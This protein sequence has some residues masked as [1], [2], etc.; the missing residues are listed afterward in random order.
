MTYDITTVGTATIDTFLEAVD[1]CYPKNKKRKENFYC[2]P[3]GGKV[4]I[5]NLEQ[6]IG[7]NAANAAVGF[8]RLKLKTAIITSFGFELIISSTQ[9]GVLP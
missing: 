4:P 8:S 7:G 3:V 5:Q 2:F 6:H 1:I 9:G